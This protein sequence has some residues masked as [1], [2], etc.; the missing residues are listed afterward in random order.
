M[1]IFLSVFGQLCVSPLKNWRHRCSD[2]GV[3]RHASA[4]AH[5]VLGVYGEA[6]LLDTDVLLERRLGS[7]QSRERVLRGAQLLVEHVQRLTDLVHLSL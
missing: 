7:A 4:H 5:A 1:W 6:V 3:E 2:L